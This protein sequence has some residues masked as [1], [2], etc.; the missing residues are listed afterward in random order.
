MKRICIEEHWGTPEMAEI[1]TQWLARTGLS[2][3]AGR[4]EMRGAGLPLAR[5]VG[6]AGGASEDR[7]DDEP[8][9]GELIVADDGVAVIHRLAHAPKA[10][11]DVVRRDRAI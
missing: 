6:P 4:A 2:W 7:H 11:E 8:A 9:V 3:S 1:K 10:P 5:L